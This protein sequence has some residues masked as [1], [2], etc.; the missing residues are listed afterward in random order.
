MTKAVVRA[1]DTVQAFVKTLNNVPPVQN[2]VVSGASKRGWTTWTTTAVDKRV[3]A[4]VPIVIPI[5][6]M[7]PNI[8]KMWQVLGEWSFALD[9][10]TS[11]G[12]VHFLNKP[13]FVEMAAVIDPYSYLSRYTN[14]PKYVICATGDEFFLPDGA[15]FFW[16]KLPGV[17]YLR[18]MPD[19]EHS[20]ADVALD[21]LL[22]ISSFVHMILENKPQPRLS[23]KLTRSDD[24][25]EIV[26][27]TIDKPK[28]VWMWSSNTLSD[29]QRDFRLVICNQLPQC[30]NPVF[31]YSTELEDQ[32]GGVY[33]AKQSKPLWGWTAFLIEVI[34]EIPS[35]FDPLNPLHQFKVT[36]EVNVVPNTLPFPP[37][38]NNC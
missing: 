11:E 3:I 4:M 19:A 12:V 23:W 20:L 5:L 33:V 9:D 18:M 14:I 32:G 2:F 28:S 29:N 15:S 38:G 27:N 17:K 37:C 26:V 1:M 34:Y 10:Y 8:N 35:N 25:A 24:I 30:F 16:D 7:I 6:N 21:V 31:W 22:S 36:T 13:Q